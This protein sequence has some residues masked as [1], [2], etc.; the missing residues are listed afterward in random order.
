ME[1]AYQQH[2]KLLISLFEVRQLQTDFNRNKAYVLFRV[3]NYHIIN[4][5]LIKLMNH[6]KCFNDNVTG[7]I[8]KMKIYFDITFYF[9]IISLM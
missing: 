9:I 6:E 1:Y 4:K 8:Y 5:Y 2:E 7:K 3:T